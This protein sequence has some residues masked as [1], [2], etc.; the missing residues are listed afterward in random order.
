MKFFCQN[1]R[2]N[3]ALDRN[4]PAKAVDILQPALVYDLAESAYYPYTRGQAYLALHKGPEAAAESQKL[5]DH[6]G[7][8][9]I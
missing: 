9:R 2:A 8:T 6:R 5:L 7:Y 1:V 3:I 4:E